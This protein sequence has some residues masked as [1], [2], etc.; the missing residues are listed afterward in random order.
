MHFKTRSAS[1]AIRPVLSDRRGWSSKP[2][3][4]HLA[5]VWLWLAF[6]LVYASAAPRTPFAADYARITAGFGTAAEY[7]SARG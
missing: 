5:S 7:T 3:S 2:A 6:A 1:L 4:S